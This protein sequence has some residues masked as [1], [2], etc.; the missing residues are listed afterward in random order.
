M[1]DEEESKKEWEEL[2]ERINDFTTF[3][4]KNNMEY[5][6]KM[7][8]SGEGYSIFINKCEI[9]FYRSGS[10]EF[11]INEKIINEDSLNSID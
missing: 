4:N 6:V 1:I 3:L 2:S 11:E 7:W 9:M 10:I 8:D 5:E